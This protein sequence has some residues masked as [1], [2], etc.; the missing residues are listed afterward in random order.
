MALRSAD[1]P[2]RPDAAALQLIRHQPGAPALRLGL[3]AGWQPVGAIGQL[4]ALLNDHS[5]WAS[6]RS[7]RDLRRML[8]HSQAAVS[9][10]DRR[11]LVGFGRA[12]SDG[13]YRAA[14]WDVVVAEAYQGQGLGRRLVTLL[15]E[16]PLLRGVER[17]Y[18]MTTNSAGF[19]SQ[20]GFEEMLSQKLLLRQQ[21]HKAD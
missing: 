5:F 10:W 19:Y 17:T 13:V 8:R 3:G 16:A 11:R 14:L 1:P 21:P 12:S 18:L 4:Q 6:G 20:L 9:A 15:L 2:S 7:T